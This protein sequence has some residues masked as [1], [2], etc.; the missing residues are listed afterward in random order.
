MLGAGEV[1]RGSMIA[2]Q[3]SPSPNKLLLLHV[4]GIGFDGSRL[5]VT[6]RAFWRAGPIA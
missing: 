4:Y 3:L 6:L 5:F 1:V 2:S